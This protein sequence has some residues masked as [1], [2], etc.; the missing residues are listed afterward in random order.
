VSE[1]TLRGRDA[2]KMGGPAVKQ[3]KVIKL[4]DGWAVATR[5]TG[6]IVTKSYP[7]EESAAEACKLCET[8]EYFVGRKKKVWVIEDNFMCEA[9]LG[10]TQIGEMQ[11]L[12][13]KRYQVVQR[14]TQAE[15]DEMVN[16][17]FEEK[18]HYP[19]T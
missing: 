3:Y 17:Y 13:M 8:S 2:K 18:G 19:D 5:A 15:F 12:D 4:E 14:F 7:D 16:E 11:T 10:G 6:E 1:A 9:G